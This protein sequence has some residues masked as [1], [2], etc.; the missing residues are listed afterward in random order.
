MTDQPTAPPENGPA[1]SDAHVI[2]GN[3]QPAYDAV[4]AYIRRLPNRDH[5][6]VVRNAMIWRAVSAALDAMGAGM[7]VSSHCVE[8]GHVLMPRPA[9]LANEWVL[10]GVRADVETP[11]PP[12]GYVDP[13]PTIPSIDLASSKETPDA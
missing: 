3:R 4:F 10:D 8:G 2:A 6:D 12:A 13:N 5:A 1:P 11:E 7:C 9:G